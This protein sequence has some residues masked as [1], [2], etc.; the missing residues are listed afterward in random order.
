[1]VEESKHTKM[2]VS[3]GAAL[4][5][6]GVGKWGKAVG[7]ALG[8]PLGCPPPSMAFPHGPEGMSILGRPL[9]GGEGQSPMLEYSTKYRQIIDTVSTRPRDPEESVVDILSIICR[10]PR[11][12]TRTA[13]NYFAP[14]KYSEY[15]FSAHPLTLL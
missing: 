15:T 3:S 9:P 13:A 10:C 8:N 14:A 1:L 7:G 4:S 12:L 2:F 5:P 11:L 6:A